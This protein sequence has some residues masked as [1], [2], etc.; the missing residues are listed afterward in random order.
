M[1]NY[2]KNS[3]NTVRPSVVYRCVQKEHESRLSEPFVLLSATAA[4]VLPSLPPEK[5]Q[6]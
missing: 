5:Q 2:I 6:Q 4:V 3:E 1:V